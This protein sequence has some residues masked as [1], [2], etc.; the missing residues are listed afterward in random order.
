MLGLGSQVAAEIATK[1]IGVAFRFALT[2]KYPPIILIDVQHD[3]YGGRQSL[4][5]LDDKQLVLFT[6]DPSLKKIYLQLV[7]GKCLYLVGVKSAPPP[8]LYG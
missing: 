4:G 3:L 7:L 5:S 1:Q 6:G 8:T 2:I